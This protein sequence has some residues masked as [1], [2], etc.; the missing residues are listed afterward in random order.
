MCTSAL[1]LCIPLTHAVATFCLH[2]ILEKI[3]QR[4]EYSVNQ[5]FPPVSPA[6]YYVKEKV[7]SQK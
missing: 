4:L 7:P 6:G 5:S 1:P 3:M 2:G